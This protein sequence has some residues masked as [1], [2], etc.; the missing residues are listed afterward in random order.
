MLDFVQIQSEHIN[1]LTK[2]II[3]LME[4]THKVGVAADKDISNITGGEELTESSASAPDTSGGSSDFGGGDDFGMGGDMDFG[5]DDST[6]DTGTTEEPTDDN[7]E[8][9]DNKDDSGS[10]DLPD[11]ASL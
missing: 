2:S 9:K 8:N 6:G 5:S 4:R 3:K 7:E 1:G 11:L 10:G